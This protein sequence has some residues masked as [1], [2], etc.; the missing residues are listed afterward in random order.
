M[1]HY[2]VMLTESIDGLNIKPDGIYID[3]TL[4]YGGHSSEILKSL[5]TG[6]LYS[7]DQDE[8]AIEYAKERLSKISDKFTII[9]SNF[10]NMKARRIR[11]NKSRWHTIRFRIIKSSNR[12]R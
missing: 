1:K 12:Q 9:H 8:E 7:F 3:G 10:A 4:G 5:T 11:S 6:H 2:S